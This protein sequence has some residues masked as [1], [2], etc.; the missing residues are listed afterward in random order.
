[1]IIF[2]LSFG[3]QRLAHRNMDNRFICVDHIAGGGLVAMC[4]GTIV[5]FR[6]LV[7]GFLLLAVGWSLV[8][9]GC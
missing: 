8:A 3:A 4:K 9:A 6:L 2:I 5:R 1:M 7:A